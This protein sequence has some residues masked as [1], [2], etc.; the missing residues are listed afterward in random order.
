MASVAARTAAARRRRLGRAEPNPSDPSREYRMSTSHDP[1][2][3][4]RTECLRWPSICQDRFAFLPTGRRAR[5]LV[6]RRAEGTRRDVPGHERDPG[7]VPDLTPGPAE[8]VPGLGAD[9]LDVLPCGPRGAGV[10][11]VRE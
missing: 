8:P 5:S 4:E 10:R 9:V 11:V 1:F 7:V 2:R 6:R 3:A